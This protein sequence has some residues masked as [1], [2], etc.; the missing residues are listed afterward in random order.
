MKTYTYA[1]VVEHTKAVLNQ[2]IIHYK[3]VKMIK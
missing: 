1:A 3:Q 2:L